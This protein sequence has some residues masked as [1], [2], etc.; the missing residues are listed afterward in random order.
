MLSSFH[1]PLVLH[2]GLVRG[3]E[4]TEEGSFMENREIPI[5]HKAPGLRPLIAPKGGKRY[6]FLLFVSRR[7]FG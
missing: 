1:H 3:T 4:V 2:G 6:P 5:L 7:P